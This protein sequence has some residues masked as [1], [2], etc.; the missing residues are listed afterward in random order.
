MFLCFSR[1]TRVSIWWTLASIIRTFITW[2]YAARRF[3]FLKSFVSRR[4]PTVAGW[5]A[6]C[7]CSNA[8]WYRWN[9]QKTDFCFFFDR[10]KTRKI[11]LWK[12]AHFCKR[13]NSKFVE[14]A[15]LFAVIICILTFYISS[16]WQL[17][18]SRL[19]ANSEWSANS[20]QKLLVQF[21]NECDV[22]ES[23]R[24]LNSPHCWTL[25]L[26]S[27]SDRWFNDAAILAI[28]EKTLIATGPTI[29]KDLVI[30]NVNFG[31]AMRIS[32]CWPTTTTMR[33]E[34]SW[35][36]LKATEGQCHDDV[37]LSVKVVRDNIHI[38]LRKIKI[39]DLWRCWLHFSTEQICTI[40]EF[41]NSLGGRLL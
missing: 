20:F 35:K 30:R 40:F 15:R 2:G 24:P 21:R 1:A 11:N 14:S 9:E 19:S 25:F 26:S 13:N 27:H 18:S 8:C 3:G 6:N 10:I 36:T 5:W 23:L 12:F 7:A 38:Q 41:Q 17:H 4:L 33:W 22:V 28:R 32:T 39:Y 34:S 16:W 37:G 31:W 29:R